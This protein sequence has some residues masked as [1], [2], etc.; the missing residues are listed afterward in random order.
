MVRWF[1]L[2]TS[3]N[4]RRRYASFGC[5]RPWPL[6]VLN[7]PYFQQSNPGSILTM[8]QVI[9]PFS[10]PFGSTPF[11]WHAMFSDTS[12][13]YTSPHWSNAATPV[14]CHTGIGPPA[15]TILFTL[16]CLLHPHMAWVQMVLP[17]KG[18]YTIPSY[19]Q[20]ALRVD[21]SLHFVQPTTMPVPKNIAYIDVTLALPPQWGTNHTHTTWLTGYKAFPD[22]KSIVL[23]YSQDHIKR[24]T[25]P[26][27]VTFQRHPAL[28]VRMT[29][30]PVLAHWRISNSKRWISL[31]ID[32]LFF[33]HHAQVDRLWYKWQHSDIENRQWQYEGYAQPLT[34][35]TLSKASTNDRV[36]MLGLAADLDVID[37]M[38]TQNG[39][40]CY[41]YEDWKKKLKWSHEKGLWSS[42]QRMCRTG[43]FWRNLCS[44]NKPPESNTGACRG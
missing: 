34:S 30:K 32:P 26:L 10:K 42:F 37:M 13:T 22:T 3:G 17:Q 44:V 28:M 40:L 25:R 7:S 16:P 18:V 31:I 43:S 41:R 33:L 14:L 5:M 19:L 6:T 38:D 35:N 8:A 2:G 9:P 39:L 12:V 36:R 4:L 23:N 1:Y 29:L 21:R 11:R 20:D 24:F 27:E 15:V